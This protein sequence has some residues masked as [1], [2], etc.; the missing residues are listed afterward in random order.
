MKHQLATETTEHPAIFRLLP[1]DH[2]SQV[3]EDIHRLI[4][5]RAYELFSDR[6]FAHG[7]ALDDWL[8]AESEIL[9]FAPLK[10]S[11]TED[12]ITATAKLPGYPAQEIEIHVEPRRLFVSA[13]REQTTDG[14]YS[15][16]LFC[17]LDLPALIDPGRVTATLS[18]GQLR[19]ELPKRKANE[20]ALVAAKAAA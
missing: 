13:D 16:P 7:H 20:K 10:I 17:S 9:E 5:R 2:F 18:N 12:A 1:E 8:Q 3:M 19:V 4:A 14:I 11:E 15:K 6:G